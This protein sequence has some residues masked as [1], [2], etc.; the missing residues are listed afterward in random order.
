[1]PESA[2]Q[3]QNGR[4]KSISE[5]AELVGV[6]R[7]TATSRLRCLTPTPGPR[8]ATLYDSAIAIPVLL[9]VLRF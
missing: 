2:I 3:T 9:G 7:R 8:N 5:L 4:M 1:M 6:D